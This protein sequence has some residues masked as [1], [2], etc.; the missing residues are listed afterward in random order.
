VWLT[1]KRRGHYLGTEVDEKWWRRHTKDKLL[2]R[3]LGE[4]WIEEGS[5]L[6]RRLLTSDP[7]AIPL[8]DVYEIKVGT[9]HSGRWAAGAPVVKVVWR[10]DDLRL[11]SGFVLSADLTETKAL[12][13]ELRAAAGRQGADA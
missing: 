4:C 2:S 11:S 5:L 13:G 3:G 10:K 1:E 7:I 6:F 12:V 8:R 9:W